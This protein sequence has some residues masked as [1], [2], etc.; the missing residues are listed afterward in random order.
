[1]LKYLINMLNASCLHGNLYP[2]LIKGIQHIHE[3]IDDGGKKGNKPNS[4]SFFM[5]EEY[6]GGKLMIKPKREGS[7][8]TNV[9]LF[10]LA[11]FEIPREIEIFLACY[12]IG[13]HL[14][15][16]LHGEKGQNI[17]LYMGTYCQLLW[18]SLPVLDDGSQIT[19]FLD[20]VFCF[21]VLNAIYH[22]HHYQYDFHSKEI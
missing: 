6:N 11:F 20:L 7:V 13:T 5:W 15:I 17:I 1:I 18:R 16:I 3:Q 22:T 12:I 19:H 21:M 8:L 4:E 14:C 10:M 2:I 9:A